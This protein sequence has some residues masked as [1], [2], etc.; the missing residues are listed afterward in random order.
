MGFSA[1]GHVAA[2]AATLFDAPAGRT[3]SPLDRTSGRPDFAALIYP[4]IT[5][6]S[7]FAHTGSHDN[8]LGRNPSAA[9]V[10]ELS[11]E[12]HVTKNTPPVFLVHTEEDMTVPVEN[13]I[14]F[15]QALRS[16]AVPA[17]LH[18]YAR[19]PHGFALANDLGPASQWPKRLEEWMRSHGWL[20]QLA[21]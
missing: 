1:G 14:A 3:G 10:N 11:A 4:V 5:M 21:K 9:L 13:S 2:T 12:L 19:G 7:P 17:E 8:L 20:D 15:Y 6:K 18:L 16:A